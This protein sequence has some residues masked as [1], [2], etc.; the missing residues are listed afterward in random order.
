MKV[1]AY[2][3]LER[4]AESIVSRHHVAPYA[5]CEER[6]ELSVEEVKAR[7]G[8]EAFKKLMKYGEVVVSD[9]ESMRKFFEVKDEV[10][11][12]KLILT[13]KT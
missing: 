13:P 5:I 9:Y 2:L 8:E 1:K 6:S 7:L 4:E 11:Y 12:V 10:S 3:C